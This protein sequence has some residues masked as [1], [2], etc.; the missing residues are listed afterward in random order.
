LRQIPSGFKKT[1]NFEPQRRQGTKIILAATYEPDDSLG[2]LASWRL[3]G[4]TFY[5]TTDEG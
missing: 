4:S 1:E 3:G 5:Y 2:V